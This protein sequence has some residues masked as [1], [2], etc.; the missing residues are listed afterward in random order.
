M[1]LMAIAVVAVF[2][3][4]AAVISWRLYATLFLLPQSC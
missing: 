4:M 3:G 1:M 2:Y